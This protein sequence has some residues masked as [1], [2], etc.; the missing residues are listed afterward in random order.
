MSKPNRLQDALKAKADG[1]EIA[2]RAA[3]ATPLKPLTEPSSRSGKIM[4]S[5]YMPKEVRGSFRLI[6]AQRPDKQMQELIA[7]AFNDL[8][9]KYNVPQTATLGD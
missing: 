7:E 2:A 5:A 1:P 9:A 8:F 4:V 6:Q 3:K